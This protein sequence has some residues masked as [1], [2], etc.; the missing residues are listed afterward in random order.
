MERGSGAMGLWLLYSEVGLLGVPRGLRSDVWLKSSA[1]PGNDP[2]ELASA[3][4][5]CAPV[6]T[7]GR[8]RPLRDVQG[9]TALGTGQVHPGT[10]AWCWQSWH[11]ERQ[12]YQ[13]NR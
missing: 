7:R 10:D 12:P 5:G 2:E 13:N 11:L 8:L 6:R 1:L 3:K 4:V 9:C